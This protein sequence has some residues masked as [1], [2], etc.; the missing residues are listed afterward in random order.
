MKLIETK[1]YKGFKTDFFILPK[2][3]RF[4]LDQGIDI[5]DH[6]M[7]DFH[8]YEQIVFELLD[9]D[10]D[11][12]WS[13]EKETR[14]NFKVVFYGII[15]RWI[16]KNPEGFGENFGFE[17]LKFLGSSNKSIHSKNRSP[18]AIR[19]IIHLD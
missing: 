17:K 5:K 16:D 4:L 2:T 3:E 1:E 18:F 13:D 15:E 14:R 12:D 7:D 11:K 19:E 6:L 10:F 9:P 8:W